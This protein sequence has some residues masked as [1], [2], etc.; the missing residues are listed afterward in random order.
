MGNSLVD[1][2]SLEARTV[3]IIKAVLETLLGRI[4]SF[5]LCKVVTGRHMSLK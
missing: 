5:V 2:K 1:P 3:H 4:A